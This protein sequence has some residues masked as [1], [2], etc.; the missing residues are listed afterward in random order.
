MVCNLFLHHFK[1]EEI[2]TIVQKLVDASKMGVVVND[3]N[4]NKLAFNLFKVFSRIFLKTHIARNDGL[5]SVA[6]GFKRKRN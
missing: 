2:I 4:R 3:L 5:V 1:N 6:R